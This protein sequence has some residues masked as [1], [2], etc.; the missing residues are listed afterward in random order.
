[1]TDVS[2]LMAAARGCKSTTVFRSMLERMTGAVWAHAADGGDGVL[3]AVLRTPDA[4]IMA[5]V[6]IHG[7]NGPLS[8]GVC[9]ESD[10][11]GRENMVVSKGKPEDVVKALFDLGVQMRDPRRDKPTDAEFGMDVACMDRCDERDLRDAIK[12]AGLRWDRCVS[13]VVNA[14]FAVQELARTSGRK[15]RG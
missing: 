9:A 6:I 3:T 8:L 13:P 10:G 4:R 11:P 2:L 15:A 14:T 1:M 12:A 5:A 7:G